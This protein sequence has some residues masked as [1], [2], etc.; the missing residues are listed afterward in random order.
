MLRLARHSP[1]TSPSC[2]LSLSLGAL[3]CTFLTHL[4]LSRKALSSNPIVHS[5]PLLSLS[6]VHNRLY[7][8]VLVLVTCINCI[9]LRSKYRQ[10]QVKWKSSYYSKRYSYS[11]RLSKTIGFWSKFPSVNSWTRRT[12]I[13]H[14]NQDAFRIKERVLTHSRECSRYC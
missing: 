8:Y 1:A 3:S 6:S 14:L 11:S 5:S 2:A 9:V 12:H 13:C 10:S 7:M 4:S